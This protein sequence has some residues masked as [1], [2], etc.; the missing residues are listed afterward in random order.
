MTAAMQID[1]YS[2]DRWH[3]ENELHMSVPLSRFATELR[4]QFATSAAIVRPMMQY[5]DFDEVDE[6]MELALGRQEYARRLQLR[7]E[8]VAPEA[9]AVLPADSF[10]RELEEAHAVVLLH[11]TAYLCDGGFHSEY[12]RKKVRH[13]AYMDARLACS[14]GPESN[15]VEVKFLPDLFDVHL[16]PPFGSDMD[17][18]AKNAYARLRDAWQRGVSVAEM[19]SQAAAGGD[20]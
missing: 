16:P 5:V 18:S 4:G 17:W 2:T 9:L 14:K 8:E 3:A 11:K 15:Q 1:V 20:E 12:A 19:G 7:G 13:L 6:R 10:P